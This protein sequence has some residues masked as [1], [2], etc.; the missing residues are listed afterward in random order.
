MSTTDTTEVTIVDKRVP[1]CEKRHCNKPLPQIKG[2]STTPF[3][4]TEAGNKYFCSYECKDEYDQA[5]TDQSAQQPLIDAIVARDVEHPEAVAQTIHELCAPTVRELPSYD[6]DTWK[7]TITRSAVSHLIGCLLSGDPNTDLHVGPNGM[8]H[9]ML[10]SSDFDLVLRRIEPDSQPCGVVK[11]NATKPV[12]LGTSIVLTVKRIG[13]LD[14]ATFYEVS[15]STGSGASIEEPTR[16]TMVT[17]E[18]AR[19]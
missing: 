11:I 18:S 15:A 13:R 10:R 2:H 1:Q 16:V 5:H 9:S 17:P 7:F 8:Q 6:A 12:P 14:H 19:T 3:S 4:T